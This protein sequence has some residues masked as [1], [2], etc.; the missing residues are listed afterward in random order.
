MAQPSLKR[1]ESYPTQFDVK[2]R[3]VVKPQNKEDEKYTSPWRWRRVVN[4]SGG[5]KI[6]ISYHHY[7][8]E[9]TKLAI[10]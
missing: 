8:S 9:T 1:Q 5:K 6:L 3:Y 10:A 7:F 2:A 4:I